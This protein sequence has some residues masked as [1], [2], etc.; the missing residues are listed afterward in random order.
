MQQGSALRRPRHD[1]P[2]AGELVV[3]ERLVDPHLEAK[4]K[5]PGGLRFTHGGVDGILFALRGLTATW[6]DEFEAWS[7]VQ[8]TG[9]SNV[10]I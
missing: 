6:I 3:L 1:V 5:E 10:G 8:S 2:A 7:Q 9:Q 4:A